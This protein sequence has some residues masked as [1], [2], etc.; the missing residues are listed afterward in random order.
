MTINKSQVQTFQKVC[1]ILPKQVFSHGQLYA[2]LH[3]IPKTLNSY[4]YFPP[5]LIVNTKIVEK[6]S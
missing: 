5:I 3:T 6:A 4:I 1:L 2:A